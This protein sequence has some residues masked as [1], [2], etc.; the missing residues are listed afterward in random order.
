MRRTY[1]QGRL[2][3]YSRRES[4]RLAL[5]VARLSLRDPPTDTWGGQ[6]ETRER[7]S[8]GSAAARTREKPADRG[9]RQI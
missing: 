9:R 6:I 5:L 8:L 4:I 7:P 3:G 1:L 2:A